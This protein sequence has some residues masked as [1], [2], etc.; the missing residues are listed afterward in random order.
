MQ[1]GIEPRYRELKADEFDD[2]V[3]EALALYSR[4]PKYRAAGGR[5]EYPKNPQLVYDLEKKR[6]VKP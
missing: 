4:L 3:N 6:R 1:S 5:T 2:A